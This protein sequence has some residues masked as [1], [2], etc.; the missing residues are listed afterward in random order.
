MNE[1]DKYKLD[2]YSR[3]ANQ[4]LDQYALRVIRRIKKLGSESRTSGDWNLINIWEG[5]KE[6]FPD[7]YGVDLRLYES[8]IQ[9][10]CADMVILYHR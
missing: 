4:R 2:L 9:G 6:Q 7:G 8:I 3:T 1:F 5:F 10:L